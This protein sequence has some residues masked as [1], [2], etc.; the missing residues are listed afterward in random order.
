MNHWE[1]RFLL[2]LFQIISSIGSIY[3]LSSSL[4]AEHASRTW[5]MFSGIFI[6]LGVIRAL[7][8]PQGAGSLLAELLMVWGFMICFFYEMVYQHWFVLI[9][10]TLFTGMRGVLSYHILF[11]ILP[12]IN[13]V[14]LHDHALYFLVFLMIEDMV[15][16]VF[17]MADRSIEKTMRHWM[18]IRILPFY[19]FLSLYQLLLLVLYLRTYQEV[20][21]MMIY[22]GTM[23]LIFNIFINFV[24]IFSLDKRIEKAETEEKLTALYTQRQVEYDYCQLANK[25]MEDIEKLKQFYISQFQEIRGM[26]EENPDPFEVAV[27]IHG[28]QEQVS[29]NPFPRFC[30]EDVVNAVLTL[31]KQRAEE[32]QIRMEISVMIPKIISVAALDLCSLFCNLLDNAIEACRRNPTIPGYVTIKA[33][34][35]RGG[36]LIIKTENPCEQQPARDSLFFRTSKENASEHGYGLKLIEQIAEKYHGQVSVKQEQTQFIVSVLLTL[37][38]AKIMNVTKC[39][40]VLNVTKY[41]QTG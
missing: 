10:W 21:R 2:C 32:E 36:Y 13:D 31:K 41:G 16:F 3:Y 7:V 14:S 30:E 27:F 11:F 20:N 29:R 35:F 37:D 4:F 9:K 15:Y 1:V 5:R 26:L 34:I 33:D 8:F 39:N 19:L 28:S 18:R 25:N 22:S 23:I 6:C 24:L 38:E 17:L 12:E 40:Q